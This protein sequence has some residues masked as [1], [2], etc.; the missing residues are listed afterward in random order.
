ML[1][2]T[3][4]RSIEYLRISVTDRC[5]YRCQY[6]MSESGISLLPHDKIITYEEITKLASIFLELGIKKIRFTGGEPLVRKGF[7]DF[8]SFFISKFPGLIVSITTNGSFL[9]KYYY[10]II[11]SGLN[12]INISLDTL[13]SYKFNEITRGGNLSEVLSGID[14]IC[15]SIPEIKINSVL[16]KNTYKKSSYD[17]IEY[18]K[19][20]NLL[21][22]FIEFMP[23]NRGVWDEGN[24]VS[25]EEFLRLLNKWGAWIPQK[26]KRSVCPG[27]ARYYR[28]ERTGQTIGVLSA[29]SD[30]FCASCNRLRLSSTGLLFPCLFSSLAFDVLTPLRKEDY[31]TVSERIFQ[32]VFHKPDKKGFYGDRGVAVSRIGG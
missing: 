31:P 15:G 23:A 6:C 20:K 10:A 19:D 13:S 32:A 18:A 21:L 26:M 2:D 29:V 12:S 5:N 22:R 11:K 27:P 28:N 1:I 30:H 3:L 16:L 7:I 8:L 9:Y 17:L 14:Y 25:A 4:G 24:Y